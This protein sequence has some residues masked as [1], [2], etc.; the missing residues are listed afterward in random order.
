MKPDGV[1][2]DPAFRAVGS[3]NQLCYTHPG[4]IQTV[5]R[6]AGEYFDG[7]YAGR[8]LPAGIQAM[9]DYLALVPN[10]TA[11]WCQCSNCAPVLARSRQDTRGQGQFS[12]AAD[13]YYVFRFINEVAKLVRPAHPK[14]YL[15]ALAYWGYYYKPLDLQLEPNISVAPCIQTCY[16]CVPA[17]YTNELTGY[18]EWVADARQTGRPLFMWNYFHHPMEP[19]VIGGWQCFPSFLPHAV[20]AEV[21]RYVRDGI[22]G[23]YLCGIGQQLDYYLYLKTAFDAATDCDALLDEFF[24]QYFGAAGEPLKRFYL[25]IEQ[26]HQAEGV[27]GT[28]KERSWGRLGTPERMAELESCINQA[29]LL[30]AAAPPVVRQRVDTWKVGVWDYMKAGFDAYRAAA[31]GKPER[32]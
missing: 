4:L 2:G 14:K 26:I 31:P 8:E 16:A 20:S 12:H 5:A 24:A 29:V 17:T 3:A 1:F 18:Q 11:H 10:D 23:V 6:L 22:H 19:A 30:S 21:K 27:L 15:A 7:A 32:Q 13:S 28:S 9:G 25:R